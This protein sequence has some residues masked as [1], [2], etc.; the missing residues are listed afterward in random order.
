MTVIEFTVPGDPVP[1]SRPGRGRNGQRYMPRPTKDYQEAVGWAA[2]EAGAKPHGGPVK[3]EIEFYGAKGGDCDNLAKSVLDGLNKIAYN[4]DR[5]VLELHV[6]LT[7]RDD[8][9]RAVI[10]ISRI[11]TKDAA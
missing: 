9:P 2:K 1:K 3:V 5:Q 8:N 6:G 10:R 7:R 11:P 4:D